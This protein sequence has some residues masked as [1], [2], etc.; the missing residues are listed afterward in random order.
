[1]ADTFTEATKRIIHLDNSLDVLAE[2][3][4]PRGSLSNALLSVVVL[5]VS[6]VT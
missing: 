6:V 3:T 1:V 2:A 4:L 5:G